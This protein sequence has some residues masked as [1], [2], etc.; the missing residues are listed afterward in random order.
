[1]RTIKIRKKILYLHGMNGSLSHEKR[2]ILE[3]YFEVLA[4]QLDYNN[5]PDMI[6]ELNKLF[7]NE[8]FSAIIGN[9]LGGCYGYYLSMNH[10]LPALI[11]NPALNCKPRSV[12]MSELKPNNSLMVIVLGGEDKI[13]PPKY[14]FMFVR[15]NPNPNYILKWYNA[16][17]HRIDIEVFK[18]EV[19]AFFRALCNQ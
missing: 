5:S 16:M 9:S 15:N 1:M 10:S 18:T 7:I 11:F 13:V 4:P 12:C 8:D 17:E 3:Q 6:G 19:E 2:E 14:T